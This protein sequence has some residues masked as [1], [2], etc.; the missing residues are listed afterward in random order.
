MRIDDTDRLEAD[1]QDP[2]EIEIQDQNAR[3]CSDQYAHFVGDYQSVGAADLLD[4]EKQYD[5]FP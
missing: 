2:I 4:V 1:P 5:A 3:L